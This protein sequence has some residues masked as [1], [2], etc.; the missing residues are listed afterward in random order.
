MVF[1]SVK[2]SLYIVATMFFFLKF[3]YCGKIYV[4]NFAV[5]TVFLK[6]FG[7]E[8]FLKSL[9]SLLQYCFCFVFCFLAPRHVG[10]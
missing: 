10:N 8:P 1:S 9:L 7:C 4:K 5:L 6:D 2:I 3:F